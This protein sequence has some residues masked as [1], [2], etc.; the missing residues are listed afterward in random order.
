MAVARAVPTITADLVGFA[1]PASRQ[2][3]RLCLE[4]LELTALPLVAK[5]TNNSVA[6]FQEGNHAELHMDINAAVDAVIL[7][8]ANQFQAGSVADVGQA[9]VLVSA[10]VA[11]E[12]PAVIGAIENGT[13]SLQFP[14]AR[15]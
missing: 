3:D 10:E 9:G 12:Y 4:N 6:I 8:S 7:K 13:P 2:Y 11:L 1:H 5:R 14:N 15:W